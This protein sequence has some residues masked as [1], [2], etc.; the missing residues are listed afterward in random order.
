[1]RSMLTYV[2]TY[3]P[4][5]VA[6]HLLFSFSAVTRGA[7]L[8]PTLSSLMIELLLLFATVLVRVF[9]FFFK[10]ILKRVVEHGPEAWL[11]LCF[12]RA[13]PASFPAKTKSKM[14]HDARMRTYA[15]AERARK[16]PAPK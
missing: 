7:V 13:P 12:M 1:M 3:L 14:Y 6:K 9:D 5:A 8:G 10:G 16:F 2:M 4:K 11:L 15:K